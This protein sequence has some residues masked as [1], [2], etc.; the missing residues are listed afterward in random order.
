MRANH[1]DAQ[2]VNGGGH[3]K[4]EANPMH[5]TTQ[6]PLR[7]RLAPR[8]GARTRSGRPCSSPAVKGKPRCRMHGGSRGSGAPKGTR[9][10]SY[11]HGAFT[12]EA[13]AERREL[14]DLVRD[15]RTLLR[16]T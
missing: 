1:G 3:M 12:C 7:L 16:D 14:R 11:K 13:I 9:N 5:Q 2:P 8:C 10:G 4:S 6:E 15:V